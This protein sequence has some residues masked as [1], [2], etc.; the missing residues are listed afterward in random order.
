MR[1]GEAAKRFG[2]SV[3]WLRRLE[4]KGRLPTNPVRDVNGHRRYTIEDL[5]TIRAVVTP[6]HS[7]GPTGKGKRD[8]GAR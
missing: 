5:D 2:I 1:V 6:S 7:S 4:R 3:D 8:G